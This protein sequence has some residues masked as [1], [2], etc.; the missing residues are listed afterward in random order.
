MATTDEPILVVDDLRSHFHLRSGVLKA[1]DGLSFSLRPG[2]VLAI[3]G[4]S[5][6]GKSVTALS[7]LRLLDPPGR[8]EG[9]RILYRGRDLMEM[10]ETEM[11]REIRGNRIAMIFQDPMT[12]LNP[13]FTIGEQIAEGIIAHRDANAAESKVLAVELLRLVGIANPEDRY[14]DYPHQF[15]GG[16]RQ[17]VLIATAIACEPDVLIADEPTTALDVTIQAQILK[18]LSDIQR[19]LGN[20]MLLITHDLGVVASMADEVM[21]MYAGHMVEY[22]DVQTVFREP[23]HP[24]TQ[25]L[26]ASLIELDDDPDKPLRPITGAPA[27]PTDL[28]PGCPF[29]PRCSH[30]FAPCDR[31]YPWPRDV[32]PGHPVACHLVAPS[33]ARTDVG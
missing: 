5:G 2:R 33:A 6:S 27:I 12:S 13:A 10:S 23:R 25:A 26:F 15:S 18:L 19:R 31:D 3:V 24:Y 20:A 11:E 30:A 22:G 1:V 32:E 16:M 7:L 29:Q 14:D 9:G 4:E 21:V 8:I 17:R 28:P